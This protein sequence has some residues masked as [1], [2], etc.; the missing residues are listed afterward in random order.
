MN[1][2]ILYILSITLQEIYL[3]ALYI[4]IEVHSILFSDTQYLHIHIHHKKIWKIYSA[5]HSETQK[6]I[7]PKIIL[8]S[9]KSFTETHV[10]YIHQH[11]DKLLYTA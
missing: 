2:C 4:Y 5:L 3:Y 6:Y 11:I 1:Y 8:R 10:V 9:L 7:V